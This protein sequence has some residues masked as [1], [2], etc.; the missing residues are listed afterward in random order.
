VGQAATIEADIYGSKVV[1]HGKVVGLAAG[2]GS[3]FS[4]LPAQNATGNWIKV[5]QR[6]PVRI[7]LDPKEL[8]QHPLRVGLSATVD[9]DISKRDGG[10]LGTVAASSPTYTTNVLNQPLQQAQAATDAIVA[11]NMAN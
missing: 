2:T 9:V 11:K 5:V 1:Y 4:L 6:V 10:A 3:A 7:S 8:A